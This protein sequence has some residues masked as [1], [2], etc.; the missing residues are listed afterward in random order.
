MNKATLKYK[1]FDKNFTTDFILD[2]KTKNFKS[3]DSKFDL[4]LQKKNEREKEIYSFFLNWTELHRPSIGLLIEELIIEPG[5]NPDYPQ[6]KIL[7]HGYQSWGF[8]KSYS[9]QEKDSSPK[10]LKFLK[11][12]QENIYTKHKGKIGNFISE[13]FLLAYSE[14][15]KKGFL[16]G[17]NES[18][19]QNVKFEIDF[20]NEKIN[21]LKLIYE[22]YSTPELKQDSPLELTKIEFS[23]FSNI[24][25]ESKL[26]DYAASLSKKEKVKLNQTESPTGWC[27][28]YY[29]YTAI[30]EEIILSNLREIKR[31]HLPFQFFQVDDGYQNEIGD[32]TIVNEKFPR[33]LRFLAEEIKRENLIPGIWLAPF[34]IRKKSQFFRNYP[35]AILKDE[36]GSPVPAQWNPLWG[37]DY[38]YTLDTT[39]PRSLE[40]LESVFKTFVKD[41]GYTYLKL[42]FLYSAS[43]IGSPYN[44]KLSPLERYKTAIEFI[45]KVVGKNIFL[46]GCGAPMM[47]SIGV[48]DGMRIGCDVTPYWGRDFLRRM[49]QDKHAL[50]TEKGL[51]NT[52]NRN[53]MHKNFWLNDPDCVITRKDK[54]KMSYEQTIMMCTVMS[55]SAGILLV[56]DNLNTITE[57]RVDILKK[58]FYLSKLCQKKKSFTLGMMKYDFPRGMYNEAG[59]LG[60]WNPTDKEE[61]VELELPTKIKFQIT[62]DYW[63]K[64]FVKD[65]EIGKTL[66]VFLKPFQTI[67]IGVK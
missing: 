16:V 55:L 33:G 41:Y 60:V 19:K 21:S 4:V 49:L 23:E 28:W 17:A 53:Y 8:V 38:T 56:S 20:T 12:G 32:W 29:Y 54:N 24:T 59:I 61:W 50:C 45:R 58:S 44:K 34:L 25:P 6:L 30:N 37:L 46:L 22:I 52:L 31:K 7:Q 47:S 13:G 57:D 5:F 2:P 51:I 10:L 9:P 66:R 67:L 15:S 43:L 42:D 40:F 63:T 3:F 48:F 64:E 65:L 14:N 36:S 62:E 39:H 26:E 35:E 1:I 27:S 11:Y 18:G